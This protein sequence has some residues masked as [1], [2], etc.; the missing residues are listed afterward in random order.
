[1]TDFIS[2]P[3]VSPSSLCWPVPRLCSFLCHSVSWCDCG[4]G[5]GRVWA[6]KG[7]QESETERPCF[8]A[9][10]GH[11]W[12]S[13]LPLPQAAQN[14]GTAS[15]LIKNVL[16]GSVG[17]AQHYGPRVGKPSQPVKSLAYSCLPRLRHRSVC[18]HAGR[19]KTTR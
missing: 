10:S 15:E 2:S 1:M 11:P 5:G 9:A 8:P 12:H 18:G 17:K 16:A 7:Q 19:F 6:S 3:S 13:W 4:G 14:C